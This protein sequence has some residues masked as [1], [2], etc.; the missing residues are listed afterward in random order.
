MKMN[1]IITEAEKKS[2]LD[3][4]K[5]FGSEWGK[6]MANVP[7]HLYQLGK[8]AAKDFVDPESYKRDYEAVKRGAKFA[9]QDPRGALKYAA[10]STD[11]FVNALANRATFGLAD[12]GQAALNAITGYD[13]SRMGQVK[14][15]KEPTDYDN[16]KYKMNMQS[17]DRKERSPSAT[18]GG[19][20]AGMVVSPPFLAGAKV[21]NVVGGKLVP[22]VIQKS[23]TP[24]AGQTT[25]NLAKGTVT[26][27]SKLATDFAGGIAATK[28]VEKGIEKYDPYDA[29]YG[30]PEYRAF[31]E[32]TELQRYKQL[33]KYRN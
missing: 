21:A 25:K 16:E 20:I 10:Q 9:A 3:A 1:E 5:E 12:K 17:L 6:E 8:D 30:A 7:G 28:G 19:D 27:P 26:V 11:D 18:K 24:V 15:I 23:L 29:Y 22:S 14:K 33:T 2:W 32:G 4:T 13:T 31:D